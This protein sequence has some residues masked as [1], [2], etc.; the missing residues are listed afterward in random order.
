MIDHR[1]ATSQNQLP[2]GRLKRATS[3][4][5][6]ERHD[7]GIAG[8]HRRN[9]QPSRRSAWPITRSATG[10]AGTGTSPS[11]CWH[12]PTWPSRRRPPQKP[13][14][15]PHPGHARRGP[16]SPGTPDHHNPQPNRRMGLVPLAPTPP[17]LRQDQ[18]L[19][20]KT[21]YISRSTAVILTTTAGPRPSREI[22]RSA[23]ERSLRSDP[24]EVSRSVSSVGQLNLLANARL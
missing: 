21:R 10:T 8:R 12:T 14:Q 2:A 23:L 11:P 9:P 6:S 5:N 16:P 3:C 19:P 18:P 4:R 24:L 17:V 20:A 22:R 13:W 7:L 1:A 15:R